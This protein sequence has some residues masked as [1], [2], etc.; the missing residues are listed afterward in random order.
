LFYKAS[1]GDKLPLLKR[2]LKGNHM[3]SGFVNTDIVIG[4][5]QTGAASTKS[6]TAQAVDEVYFG[7]PKT[8]DDL[9]AEDKEIFG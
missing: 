6:S 4:K 9:E 1:S 7:K 3:R 5:P 8:I 2:Q